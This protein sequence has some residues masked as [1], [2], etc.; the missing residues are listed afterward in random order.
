VYLSF[1]DVVCRPAAAAAA[2][3]AAVAVITM[4]VW[5]RESATLSRSWVAAMPARH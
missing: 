5:R 2:A 1:T 4:A 3:A